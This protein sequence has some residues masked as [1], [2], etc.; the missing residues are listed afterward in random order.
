MTTNNNHR[1]L[2][3][4]GASSVVAI[5]A[6]VGLAHA[7]TISLPSALATVGQVG[8]GTQ[9]IVNA[10]TLVGAALS[11]SYAPGTPVTGS[12]PLLTGTTIGIETPVGTGIGST[13][14]G[15]NLLVDSNSTVA[16][17][18]GNSGV[19]TIQSSLANNAFNAVADGLAVGSSQSLQAGAISASVASAQVGAG[20][21]GGSLPP[22]ASNAVTNNEIGA[23]ANGNVSANAIAGIAP[24]GPAVAGTINATGGSLLA[25]ANAVVANGQAAVVASPMTSTVSN[26]RIA[27]RPTSLAGTTS[28]TAVTDNSIEAASQVNSTQNFI[29]F[30][31]TVTVAAVTG[32]IPLTQTGATVLNG[33]AAVVNDQSASGTAAVRAT[34]ADSDVVLDRA[35][36]NVAGAVTNS[37]NRIAA[38]A[39]VNR[40]ELNGIRIDGLDVRSAT[41]VPSAVSTNGVVSVATGA[42]LAVVN[43]QNAVSAAPVTATLNQTNVQ[44]FGGAVT[45][46]LTSSDNTL[47]AFASGNE[48][49]ANTIVI[50]GRTVDANAAVLNNQRNLANTFAD[51]TYPDVTIDVGSV[52]NG[53]V[54]ATGNQ[55]IASAGGNTA[56]NSIAVSNAFD[57]EANG[58]GVAALGPVGSSFLTSSY[59]ILSSQ[60]NAGSATSSFDD[61]DIETSL[62][63]AVTGSSIANSDNRVASLATGNAATNSLAVDTFRFG[64]GSN[65]GQGFNANQAVSAGLGVLS[66]QVNFGAITANGN[67]DDSSAFIDAFGAVTNSDLA[68]QGNVYDVAATGN[69][70]DSLVFGGVNDAG[71]A[72]E[73]QAFGFDGTMALRAEQ[74]NAGAVA[75]NYANSSAHIVAGGAVSGGS[76]A[77][78]GN[79]L[80]ASATGNAASNRVFLDTF[81]LGTQGIVQPVQAGVQNALGLVLAGSNA[82]LTAVAVQSSGNTVTSNVNFVSAYITA[83]AAITGSDISLSGNQIGGAA[84]G[85]T[86]TNVVAVSG[87]NDAPAQRVNGTAAVLSNQTKT[88]AVTSTVSNVSVTAPLGSAS[89]SSVD[90]S[91]NALTSLAIG[92]TAANAVQIDAFGLAGNGAAVAGLDSVVPGLPLTTASFAAVNSQSATGSV[93]SSLTNATVALSEGTGAN[94]NFAITGNDLTSTAISNSASNSVSLAAQGTLG[95]ANASIL[96]SQNATGG[97]SSSVTG[98]AVAAL[99]GNAANNSG[100]VGGNAVTALSGGNSANNALNV[101]SFNSTGTGLI[102]SASSAGTTSSPLAITSVQGN[103]GAHLA[104]VT[105]AT[106]GITSLNGGAGSLGSQRVGGNSIGAVGVANEAVNRIALNSGSGRSYGG[107]A[108]NNVQTNLA[109]GNVTSAVTGAQIGINSQFGSGLSAAVTGNRISASATGNSA[110]NSIG[111]N[112]GSF[113]GSAR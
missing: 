7:A 6:T 68:V 52:T 85:N 27:V 99:Y 88:G 113:Y 102:S 77:V 104:T 48:A 67:Q 37:S 20:L 46:S 21:G 15:G 97:S 75:A 60:A 14:P 62:N 13:Q 96:N 29:R 17:A 108:I 87:P 53:A 39:G 105:N 103:S 55:L 9:L 107:A 63:G 33:N 34:V 92:N 84:R 4:L 111:G 36:N 110:I 3:L 22:V 19:S 49:A 24:V 23:F 31:P 91:N 76:L 74:A 106:V 47:G 54:T 72:V 112:V 57:I 51:A 40:S 73:G 78:D 25:S 70:T 83:P 44:T 43:N 109:G 100:E 69:R 71:N 1:R 86:A 56:A 59:G 98:A 95:L 80:T 66:E 28:S 8:S 16:T 10:Q 42:D 41:L 90:L 82:D 35:G 38:E 5:G 11:A 2:K 64:S 12:N 26:S 81:S 94:S 101:A 61:T 89:L 79:L 18:T 45:G 93:T 58:R 65:V 32:T 50:E 30:N